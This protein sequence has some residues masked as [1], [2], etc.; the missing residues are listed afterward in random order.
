MQ[1]RR[2]TLK[3]RAGSALAKY[4]ARGI[5]ARA[6]SIVRGT[7]PTRSGRVVPAGGRRYQGPLGPEL[8]YF[9]L[10]LQTSAVNSTGVIAA[11]NYPN[12]GSGATQRIGRRIHMKNLL[13][14]G[15]F[16]PLAV[17]NTSLQLVKLALVYDRQYNG[18]SPTLGDIFQ[19]RYGSAGATTATDVYSPMNLDNRDRFVI[20]KD[21]YM[22][23][24]A[25]T[26]A[27]QTNS[28]GMGYTRTQFK[29]YVNL[30]NYETHFK[31]S[32]YANTDIATGALLF[33]IV[34]GDASNNYNLTWHS[35]LKFIDV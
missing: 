32:T 20:L 6:N 30:K 11:L 5:T 18:A 17:A 2:S 15:D 35:R 10:P 3:P 16:E 21:K 13:I 8:K 22:H 19:Y 28:P 31:A 7:S 33:V 1:N 25:T 26:V 24:P 12:E 4:I 29:W 34:A 9:D 14:R 27:A 23:L